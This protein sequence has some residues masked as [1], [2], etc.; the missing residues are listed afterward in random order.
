MWDQMG[1]KRDV[2][3]G[4]F[5]WEVCF[6]ADD[7]VGGFE[8]VEGGED[9]GGIEGGVQWHQYRAQLEE[10]VCSL[11]NVSVL[12][13]VLCA[14][15]LLSRTR[16]CCPTTRPLGLPCSLLSSASLWRARWSRGRALR[17]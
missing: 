12:A 17:M 10:G 11:R 13:C 6:G 1:E 3:P 8:V 5:S 9:L 2:G 7:D 16:H 15:A 14:V 4:V